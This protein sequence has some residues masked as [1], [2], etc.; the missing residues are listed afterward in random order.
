MN[1]QKHKILIIV[2][3][4]VFANKLALVI[5]EMQIKITMNYHFTA[6]RMGII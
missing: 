2:L 1:I 6:T 4:V 5:M 3:K